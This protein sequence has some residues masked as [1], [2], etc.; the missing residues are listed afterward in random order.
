V[1]GSVTFMEGSKKVLGTASVLVQSSGFGATLSPLLGQGSHTITAVYS[2][3]TSNIGSTSPAY[4]EVVNSPQATTTTVSSSLNPSSVGQA[5]TFTATVSPSTASGLVQFVQGQ[6][7]LGTAPLGS[8]QAT[9][10]T[11]TL[12]AG[13]L[14]IIAF[15]LGDSLNASSASATLSQTVN[16]G[17]TATSIASFPNPSTIFQPVTV[18]AHVTVTSSNGGTPTGTITF[19]KGNTAL[20]PPVSLDSSGTAKLV[21]SS[22]SLGNNNVKAVYGGSPAYMGSTSTAVTQVVNF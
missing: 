13:N 7:T 22:L 4:T 12:P 17:S 14:L 21:T 15:Y 2:G 5:V 19:M 11:S 3:D 8:G 6:T 9:F 16:K 1:G 10:T 18:V 20:A